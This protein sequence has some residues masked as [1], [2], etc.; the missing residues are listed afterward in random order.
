VPAPTNRAYLLTPPGSAAIAVVRACGPGVAAFLADY[1]AGKPGA[2]RASHGGLR[3]GDFNDGDRVIDDPVVV[4]VR[5]DAADLNLHGGP[6]V[7]RS[8]L[9][10]LARCGFDVVP[11]LPMPLPDDVLDVIAEPPAE[12]IERDVLAHL[13]LARTEAAVRALLAQPAAWAAFAASCP[14]A[15]DTAA[16]LADRMLERML[17]P[18]RVAVVGGANVGKSTLANRLFGQDRSITADL[19]GTTRDWVGELADLD[20]VAVLLVDTPGLRATEDPI[21]QAAIAGSRAQVAAADVVVVVFDAGRPMDDEQRAPLA[22]FSGA[23]VVVNKVDQPAAW[24]R[25][26]TPEFA[27]QEVVTVVAT[28]G[29][30]VADLR[31]AILRRLG[32][33]GVADLRRPRCWTDGQRDWLRRWRPVL[34]GPP[35]TLGHVLPTPRGR[36]R[37]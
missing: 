36:G 25:S 29:D 23:L 3:D 15:A 31:R 28:T 2:G 37:E 4:L 14:P 9:N 24:D 22:A 18:A 19:P 11:Q 5:P 21:E 16:V 1:F 30:G 6:W 34:G 35:G 17:A 27:G 26:A 8:T 13:P 7:V 33:A 10:L 32:C 12:A 20:G